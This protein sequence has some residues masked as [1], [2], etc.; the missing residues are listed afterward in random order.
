MQHVGVG[1]DDMPLA[2]DCPTG[3]LRGVSVIGKNLYFFAQKFYGFIQL[4][5]LILAEGFGREKVYRP[6]RR[7]AENTIQ[8][9][10]VVTKRF[11]GSGR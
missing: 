9:R 11:A 3:I 6:T 8:H 1:D 7:V 2:A 4:G 5:P 10:Q